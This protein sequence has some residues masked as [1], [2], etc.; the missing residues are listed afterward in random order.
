VTLPR[1]SRRGGEGS[2]VRNHHPALFTAVVVLSG[3]LIA[4]GGAKSPSTPTSPGTPTPP[5]Q[6]NRAPVINSMNVAPTFGIASL[7]QFAFNA[8]ASDPDGDAITYSWDMAGNSFA[9]SS[10]TI[11][12]SGG[13]NGAARLTV[14]DTKGATATDTRSFTVGTMT[15]SWV[16]TVGP[17]VGSSFNL[18]QSPTGLVTGTFLLP[19]I[20][21]GN[22]DPAQPGRITAAAQLT[23]RVKIAPFT[24]FNMNGTMDSTGRVVSGSLQ[25]SGFSG[26][27]FTMVK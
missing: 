8:S 16:V 7:T 10:G 19:G 25:G 4:C 15:G 22:T 18:T 24:D 17:L 1:G 6:Q 21:S 2:I 14:A 9:G 3:V 20:G 12:F 27:P 11:T 13:G 5:A 23:M 26:Q